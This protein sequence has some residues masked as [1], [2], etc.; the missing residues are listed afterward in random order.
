ME[1]AIPDYMQYHEEVTMYLTEEDKESR[2]GLHVTIGMRRKN[3]AIASDR[4]HYYLLNKDN[5]VIYKIEK[6]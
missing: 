2:S 1:N 4:H 6:E 5:V 3:I